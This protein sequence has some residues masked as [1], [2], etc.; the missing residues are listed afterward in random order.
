MHTIDDVVGVHLHK[1][2]PAVV[3][4]QYT[5]RVDSCLHPRLEAE[6][7]VVHENRVPPIHPQP[8]QGV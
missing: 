8:L 1:L 6:R 5:H 2:L 7:R 4:R 3:A